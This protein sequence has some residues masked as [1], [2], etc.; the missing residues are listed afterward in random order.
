MR[1]AGNP[2]V[3]PLYK[4]DNLVIPCV[5][6]SV[7][8]LCR[9]IESV[10]Q[11][12]DK[13]NYI[14]TIEPEKR[15][16]TLTANA[17]YWQLVKKI[18]IPVNGQTYMAET[19]LHNRNLAQVGI[20][21]EDEEGHR[22]WV[23]LKDNEWWLKQHETHFCPSDK[24]ATVSGQVFRWF[25]LLLPSHL[26]DKSEMSRLI[27][28]VVEDARSIGIETLPPDEIERLKQLWKVT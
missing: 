20:P 10:G 14:V 11:I 8:E 7:S 9:L 28:Y 26:M 6:G 19:E 22:Q 25:Y 16:R 24:T 5:K 13:R 18:A 1:L 23:L 17:Y 27:D 2:R 12:D 4:T 21:W 3:E 15:R